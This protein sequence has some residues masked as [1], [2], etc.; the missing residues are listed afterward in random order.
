MKILGVAGLMGSGKSSV[1]QMVRD[2]TGFDSVQLELADPLKDFC[3]LVYGFDH[4]QLY[5]ASHRR[6]EPDQRYPRKG[7][8]CLTAREALQTLGTEWGRALYEDTWIN[9]GL[10][11]A[12]EFL[13]AGRKL[14]VIPGIR[15]VNE[16]KAI[17]EA[18]GQVWFVD[19]QEVLPDLPWWN[20]WKKKPH[21][22]EL[23]VLTPEFQD[24]VAHTVDNNGDFEDLKEYVAMLLNV[25]YRT[26]VIPL[27]E[28]TRG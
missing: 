14:V 21:A 1:A 17:N 19:R 6:N 26:N 28:T 11:R 3:K 12:Q 24:L 7:R 22:S 20:F 25:E 18:G 5:G 15:F 4:A 10:R 13:D 27:K 16:A 23:E 9:L 8:G 2:M